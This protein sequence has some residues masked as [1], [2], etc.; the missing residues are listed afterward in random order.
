VAEPDSVHSRTGGLT[1]YLPRRVDVELPL[2]ITLSTALYLNSTRLEGE[3]FD[4]KESG[5]GQ[6]IEEGNAAQDLG[7][8]RLQVLA[9]GPLLDRVLGEVAIYPSAITPNG[10]GRNDWARITYVLFGVETAQVEVEFYTLGG[11]RVRRL[12]ARQ[13]AGPHGIEW[14]GR[15]EAGRIVAP[16]LYL[17]R[18]RA[19]TERETVSGFKPIP[20]VY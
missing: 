20:V 15:D 19:Q 6:R 17:C 14:D 8:D 7:T 3:V 16:G 13:P 5:L 11:E 12:L 18:V 9:L 4:R 1:V 2:R 10:D